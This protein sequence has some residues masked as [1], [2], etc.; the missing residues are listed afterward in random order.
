MYLPRCAPA[1]AIAH[2]APKYRWSGTIVNK[3]HSD[4]GCCREKGA[5]SLGNTLCSKGGLI[6]TTIQG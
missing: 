4:G 3:L 6:K 1:A 5:Y 2:V